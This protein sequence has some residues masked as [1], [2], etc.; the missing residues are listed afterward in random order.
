[1]CTCSKGAVPGWTSSTCTCRPGSS[2]RSSIRPSC[3]QPAGA[4]GLT[5]SGSQAARGGDPATRLAAEEGIRRRV[6]LH[7]HTADPSRLEYRL[8]LQGAPD[9]A[10][11]RLITARWPALLDGGGRWL[12]CL[13]WRPPYRI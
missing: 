4:R 3:R 7:E 9:G 11:P 12:W 2:A 1:M 5:P 6:S 13:P 10:K 8:E